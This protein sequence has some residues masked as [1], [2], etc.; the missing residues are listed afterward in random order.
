[1]P[2]NARINFSRSTLT[3]TELMAA[4]TMPPGTFVAGTITLD[5][6]DAEVFVD[7]NGSAKA[8]TVVDAGGQSDDTDIVEDRFATD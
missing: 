8:A 5:Y 6:S 2:N 1:M 3:L 4:A 7:E